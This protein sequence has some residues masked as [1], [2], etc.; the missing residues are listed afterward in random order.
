M[1]HLVLAQ[2]GYSKGPSFSKDLNVQYTWEGHVPSAF[3]EL[4]GPND[5]HQG[6]Q[7][8]SSKKAALS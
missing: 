1:H 2:Y 5:L 6:F 8:H 7:S 4:C 3:H